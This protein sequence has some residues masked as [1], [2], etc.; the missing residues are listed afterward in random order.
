MEFLFGFIFEII[1]IGFLASVYSFIILFIFRKIGKTKLNNWL[2]KRLKN[3]IIFW[4]IN[5]ALISI[6]LF[7]WTF[8]YW[9]EHGFGD[10]S[11]IPIGNAKQIEQIDGYWTYITPKGH[12]FE[13]FTIYSYAINGKYCTGKTKQNSNR[14]YIWNLKTNEVQTV[15]SKNEYEKLSKNLNLPKE[16]EFLDFWN[17]YKKYWH[18]WRFFLLP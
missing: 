3:S 2:N 16:N 1:K 6:S 8:T 15:N 4:F 17:G 11:R 13:V 10:Y 5:G 9:G 14:Y 18:G 7:I 12:K